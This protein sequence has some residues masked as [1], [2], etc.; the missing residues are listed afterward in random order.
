MIRRRVSCSLALACVVIA[1]SVSGQSVDYR[2]SEVYRSKRNFFE[3]S[4]FGALAVMPNVTLQSLAAIEN[5]YIVLPGSGLY[6]IGRG[7]LKSPDW[8]FI[9]N[10]RSGSRVSN[11]PTYIGVLIAKRLRQPQGR[12]LELFRNAG[13]SG[14]GPD[15]L[16]GFQGTYD[17][18]KEFFELQGKESQQYSFEQVFGQWHARPDPESIGTCQQL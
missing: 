14:S 1:S 2:D 16:E 3:T 10:H 6:H 8:W 13:W 9:V 12:S 5:E 17:S 15:D 18:L 4:G 11:R 7:R